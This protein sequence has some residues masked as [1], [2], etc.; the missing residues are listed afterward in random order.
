MRNN[1]HLLADGLNTKEDNVNFGSLWYPVAS[2]MVNER[3][4]AGTIPS[5]MRKMPDWMFEDIL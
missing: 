4:F 1:R 3:K 5:L 2:I